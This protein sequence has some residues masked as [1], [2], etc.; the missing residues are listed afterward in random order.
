M[1]GQ[2]LKNHIDEESMKMHEKRLLDNKIQNAAN[3]LWTVDLLLNEK[4]ERWSLLAE[5]V[6]AA[7]QEVIKVENAKKDFLIHRDLKQFQ[8]QIKNK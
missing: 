2:E 4:Q 8:E 7:N 3:D 1:T 6:S 5:Q